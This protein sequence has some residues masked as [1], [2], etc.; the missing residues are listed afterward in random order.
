M[1]VITSISALDKR[2]RGPFQEHPRAYP[3]SFLLFATRFVASKPNNMHAFLTAYKESNRNAA[4][5]LCHRSSF[6]YI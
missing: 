2:I 4:F 6:E 1:I 3:S 5:I